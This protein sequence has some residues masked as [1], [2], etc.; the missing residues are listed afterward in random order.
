M[1]ETG[2][3]LDCGMV[4]TGWQIKTEAQVAS[5]WPTN[6]KTE[7]SEILILTEPAE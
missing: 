3:A 1:W 2:C 5:Y 6:T 4:I 7:S